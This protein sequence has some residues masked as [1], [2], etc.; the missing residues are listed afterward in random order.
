MSEEIKDQEAELNG[1]SKVQIEKAKK[2]L[3][4]IGIFSIIMLFA[5]LTSAYIVSMGDSFW[6]KYPLPTPF[7]I[8]TAIILLSS[9]T[10]QLAVSAAQKG[11]SG[12]L[13][14]MISATLVLGIVFVYFQFKGYGELARM[15]SHFTGSGI[16]VSD[17]R[18]GDYFSVKRDG[19]YIIVEGNDYMM[20]GRNLKDGEMKELQKY[21]SQFLSYKP[22]QTFNPSAD[23]T[24][25]LLWEDRELMVLDGQLVVAEDSTE[26]Q[27][28]DRLRLYQ[29]AINIR[30]GRGHFFMSGKLGEDFHI[31]YKR[32]GKVEEM[33]YK[34]GQLMLDGKKIPAWLNNKAL[35][36][37]DNASS[38]LWLITFV[39]LLHIA[40][41]M[42]Y[43]V[44]LVMRSYSGKIN[45]ENNISIR[46]GAIFW[47]FL[48]LLWLYL[49]LFLL[50]IH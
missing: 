10:I 6:V 35:S 41:T 21:M 23:G 27:D 12:M 46:M 36:S 15:G 26:L 28:L 2:N 14:S 50:F 45:S 25:T 24:H 42:F 1:D 8:S 47:H 39:H 20:D 16:V 29:L 40:F 22:G 30:D 9:L 38:Y 49:L 19:K 43:L 18:Y 17:G 34:E 33:S 44:R 3:V 7:W 37:A 4:Y 32:D 13:K 5:G 48:G 31:Y 11:N